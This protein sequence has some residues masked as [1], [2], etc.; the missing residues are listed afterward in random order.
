MCFC[1]SFG[2]KFWICR[3]SKTEKIHSIWPFPWK[4]SVWRNPAQERTN[5]NTRIYLKPILPYNNSIYLELHAAPSGDCEPNF[6]QLLGQIS[7]NQMTVETLLVCNVIWYF[8]LSFKFVP[9]LKCINLAKCYEEIHYAVI[10]F[11]HFTGRKKYDLISS[12]ACENSNFERDQ[13]PLF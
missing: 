12:N 1:R 10:V 11:D 4:R 7:S 6:L 8:P 3:L 5:Q 2:S 13:S 9:R